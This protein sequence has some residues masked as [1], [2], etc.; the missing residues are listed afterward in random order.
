MYLCFTHINAWEGTIMHT[1]LAICISALAGSTALAQTF[2]F[3]QYEGQ[4]DNITF[5]SSGSAALTIEDMGGG[6]LS[7][8]IDLGGFVFGQGD[9]PPVSF[10]AML[11]GDTVTLDPFSD[12][13]Y[14]DVSG[15]IDDM[16][17]LSI[18]LLNPAGGVFTIVELRGTAIGD[19]IQFDY[20]IFDAAGPFAMGEINL[21][22]VPPASSLALMGLGGLIAIRRSR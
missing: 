10:T 18:D 12:A 22:L 3:G 19:S 8:T 2:Q 7:G 13:T 5:G 16:G 1:R 6:M 20:D 11:S 14:G 15:D 17:N 4:W 21:R 9:P